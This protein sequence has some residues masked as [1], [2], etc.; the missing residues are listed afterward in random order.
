MPLINNYAL[1]NEDYTKAFAN[2]N[3]EI[4]TLD[5]YEKLPTANIGAALRDYLL[6]VP[7]LTSFFK[8]NMFYYY[9]QD[10]SLR[11]LP[12]LNMYLLDETNPSQ[13]GFIDG[14]LEFSI[15][16]PPSLKRDKVPDVACRISNHLAL[17]LNTDAPL[18]YVRDYSPGLTNLSF[19]SRISYE[20]AYKLDGKKVDAYIVVGVANFSVNMVEYYES[21]WN[22][23]KYE[24]SNILV[25]PV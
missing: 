23:V 3:D 4:L 17:V 24:G 16:L 19:G 21:L 10:N 13:F 14:R 22:N 5:T 2:E 7:R 1:T 12:A 11:S 8:E 9:R 15:T 6:T 25:K 20:K 18:Y